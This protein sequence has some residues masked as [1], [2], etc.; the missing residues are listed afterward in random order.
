MAGLNTPEEIKNAAETL[1]QKVTSKGGT[2]ERA[3]N[4]LE[5]SQVRATI[6]AAASAAAAR[7]RE[8]GEELGRDPQ[9]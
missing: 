6:I 3:I 1:R 4:A 2:T 7:S 8:L 5:T 9:E